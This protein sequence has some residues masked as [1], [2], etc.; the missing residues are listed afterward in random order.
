MTDSRPLSFNNSIAALKAINRPVLPQVYTIAVWV[1]NLR[2]RGNDHNFLD[3][4][5]LIFSGYSFF[6][7]V[8][9]TILSSIMT[10]LSFYALDHM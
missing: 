10:K 1:T 7:V 5:D 9:L 8:P 2:C 3:E 6:N 4:D